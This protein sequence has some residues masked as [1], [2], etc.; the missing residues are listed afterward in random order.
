MW[1]CQQE[2]LAAVKSFRMP[3]TGG[4]GARGPKEASESLM[5]VSPK[6]LA[7][8]LMSTLHQSKQGGGY[9]CS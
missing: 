5:S 8:A 6:V 4:S 7:C 3:H 1:H 2:E 9:L